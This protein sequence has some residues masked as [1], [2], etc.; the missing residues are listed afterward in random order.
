MHGKKDKFNASSLL[1]VKLKD[2]PVSDEED[3]IDFYGSLPVE[4]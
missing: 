4:D 3:H 2:V 1:H